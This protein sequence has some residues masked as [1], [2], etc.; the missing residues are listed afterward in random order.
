MKIKRRGFTLIELMVVLTVIGVLMG[1]ALVSHQ[2]ARKSARDGKRKA[3]LEQ[4]RS[5]LEMYRADKEEYPCGSERDTCKG[6][7]GAFGYN[8]LGQGWAT[9]NDDGTNCYGSYPAL[10]NVLE[11]NGYIAD[12]PRDP[13]GGGCSGDAGG[14]KWGYMYYFN[15]PGRD[16]CLYARLENPPANNGCSGCPDRPLTTYNKNFCVKNP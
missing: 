9:N 13:V 5:A 7:S 11:N 1:L 14:Y 8:G 4:I 12:F 2:G 15:T 10:E 3:D 6:T 16:Y